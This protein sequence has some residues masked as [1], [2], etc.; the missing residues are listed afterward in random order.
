MGPGLNVVLLIH[1]LKLSHVV[2][3]HCPGAWEIQF[4]A[5]RQDLCGE[6]VASHRHLHYLWISLLIGKGKLQ[7][8]CY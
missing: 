7:N 4:S 6:Q 8:T 3:P 2:T 1:W 5:A